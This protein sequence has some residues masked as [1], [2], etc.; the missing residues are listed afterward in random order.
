MA[1]V[2]A[3]LCLPFRQAEETVAVWKHTVCEACKRTCFPYEQEASGVLSDIEDILIPLLYVKLIARIT[4]DFGLAGVDFTL[5]YDATPEDEDE[6][7]IDVLDLVL[8][9]PSTCVI[10]LTL[11][12]PDRADFLNCLDLESFSSEHVSVVIAPVSKEE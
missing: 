9:P 5:A 2:N 7:D 8:E 3:T 4:V 12:D 6:V 1:V 11:S 10:T